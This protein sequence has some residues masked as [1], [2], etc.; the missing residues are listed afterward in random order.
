MVKISLQDLFPGDNSPPSLAVR[1]LLRLLIIADP[2]LNI[3][4]HAKPFIDVAGLG[5]A[6]GVIPEEKLPFF[7]FQIPD[8]CHAWKQGAL[9]PVRQRIIKK[10]VI[11]LSRLQP[12]LPLAKPRLLKILV[13]QINPCRG[14]AG[15]KVY[16]QRQR[17]LHRLSHL[18]IKNRNPPHLH[19]SRHHICL[20]LI[21]LIH[22]LRLPPPHAVKTIMLHPRFP[23]GKPGGPGQVQTVHVPAFGNQMKDPADRPIPADHKSVGPRQILIIGQCQP[24]KRSCG[25]PLINHDLRASLQ[26]RALPLLH[27]DSPKNPGN[28]L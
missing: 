12:F 23:A 20:S 17:Q 13:V 5:Q 21:Q 2:P 9:L 4:K 25:D 16:S 22:P 6:D 15:S 27:P 24:V 7:P 11:H 18:K 19:L 8:P 28:R 10:S 26:A 3:I 14:V 1:H